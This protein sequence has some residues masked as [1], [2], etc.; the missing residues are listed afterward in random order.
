MRAARIRIIGRDRALA[1][2][3]RRPGWLLEHSGEGGPASSARAAWQRVKHTALATRHLDRSLVRPPTA[4]KAVCRRKAPSRTSTTRPPP[5]ST[6]RPT[7]GHLDAIARDRERRALASPAIPRFPHGNSHGTSHACLILTP[8][9]SPPEGGTA[10]DRRGGRG[11][12]DF[13]PRELIVNPDG[14]RN[15]PPCH[16]GTWRTRRWNDAA[17]AHGMPTFAPNAAGVQQIGLCPTG[18]ADAVRADDSGLAVRVIV[19]GTW[20]FR[21]QWT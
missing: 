3:R 10:A 6:G 19:D 8:L 17:W 16:C 1:P 11:G 2:V 20:G 13:T 21:R 15:S 9:P 7:G 14:N 18:T 4:V 5:P 12:I